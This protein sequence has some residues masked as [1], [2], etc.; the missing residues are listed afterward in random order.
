MSFPNILLVEDDRDYREA[1]SRFLTKCNMSIQAVETAEQMYKILPTLSPDILILDINLP[2]DNGF[3]ALQKIRADFNGA[4]IILSARKGIED[5]V[6]GLSDGADY[7]L[8][9]PVNMRELVAVIHSLCKSSKAPQQEK[10]WLLDKDS[11]QLIAPDGVMVELSTAE[12]DVISF[13]VAHRGTPVSRDLLF[14]EL[15]KKE[16]SP[17]DR[18]L[19]VLISRLRRKYDRSQTPLPVKSVRNRGYLF[20]APIT[21]KCNKM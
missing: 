5:K 12:F 14:K 9:K 1:V 15:G 21:V 17:H 8:P 6:S 11:W 2:G 3:K 20:P 10:T 18:S 19:D 16:P 13:L 7:Y 4:V